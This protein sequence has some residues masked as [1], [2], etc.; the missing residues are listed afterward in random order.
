MNLLFPIETKSREFDYKLILAHKAVQSNPDSVA[1]IGSIPAIH[2]NIDKFQNGL[3]ISKT[4]FT[5]TREEVN[6]NRYKRFKEKDFDIIHL[7]E[8]GGVFAGDSN[9]WA[10]SLRKLYN[11][12]VFDLNDVL[13]VWGNTQA[14]IESARRVSDVPIKVTGHPRFDL[15]KD[16]GNLYEKDIE[17]IKRAYGRYI[18]INSNFATSNFGGKFSDLYSYAYDPKLADDKNLEQFFN[19]LIDESQQMYHMIHLVM[20]AATRFKE[21]NFIYRPHPSESVDFYKSIFSNNKNVIVIREGAVNPY[22]LGSIGVIHDGCTT[23]LESFKAGKP[24]MNYKAFNS[25]YELYLPNQVGALVKSPI[26]AIDVINQMISGKFDLASLSFEKK[27]TDLLY[28]LGA[29]DSFQLLQDIIS[30][31]I[32]SKEKLS[33]PL[34]PSSLNF[35]IWSSKRRL[36]IYLSRIKNRILNNKDKLIRDAYILNKY[37]GIS[38]NELNYKIDVLNR[39]GKTGVKCSYFTKEIVKIHT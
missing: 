21:V 6:V 27:A 31:K 5:S 30:E 22:I 7:H 9:D 29:E 23:S 33:K 13:C 18:L 17:R 35:L 36:R 32:K 26:E 12:N 37:Q 38:K 2:D 3:Y 24:V 28:N 1:F 15:N 10:E 34:H 39:Q 8:E 20:L 19:Y 11:I 14:E 25:Q 16:Y 4:I